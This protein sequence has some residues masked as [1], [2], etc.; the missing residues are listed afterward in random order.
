MAFEKPHTSYIPCLDGW[1]AIAVCMVVAHHQVANT[2]AQ[3]LPKWLHIDGALGVDVFF[4]ISGYLICTLLLREEADTGSINLSQ[5]YVR[6]AFRI[7]PAALTYLL[8]ICLLR[9]A[10]CISSVSP[11]EWLGSIFFVRNLQ[12]IAPS[13]W[14]TNQ[15]WSLAVEEHFYLILPSFLFLCRKGRLSV[16][17]LA[18]VVILGAEVFTNHFHLMH[19]PLQF[20]DFRLGALFV[21]AAVAVAINQGLRSKATKILKPLP[22]LVFS[23]GAVLF[24]RDN[25]ALLAI[26][27][28]MIASVLSTVLNPVRV[29]QV[30][31]HPVLRFVG[32]RSYSIYLWQQLFFPVR[33]GPGI[34]MHW[35]QSWPVSFVACFGISCLSYQYIEQPMIQIGRR[36]IKQR[37]TIEPELVSSVLDVAR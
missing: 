34:E 16:L 24:L 21:A 18:S 8:C 13:T 31:E 5:F 12:L 22:V 29:G 28:V 23:L 7:L 6:R 25:L 4:A 37:S 14:Y 9:V 19:S 1:R 2:A 30:L 35:I 15:F 26:P 27:F 33:Y 20:S 17:G 3:S 10:G 36:L 32:R 11:R